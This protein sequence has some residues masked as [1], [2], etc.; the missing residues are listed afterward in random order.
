MDDNPL[1][2]EK[3]ARFLP[4]VLV[5]GDNPFAIRWE[6]LTN[7]VRCSRRRS[8]EQKS[9]AADSGRPA[10]QNKAASRATALM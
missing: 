2:R 5:I 9:R 1:E 7:A 10:G 4:D 6:L 3:V 8:T